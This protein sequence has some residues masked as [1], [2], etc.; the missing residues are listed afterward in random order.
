MTRGEEGKGSIELS[1]SCKGLVKLDKFSE[2]DPRIIVKEQEDF[3]LRFK[4]IGF[5]EVLKNSPNPRFV[6][7]VIVPYDFS[8][9]QIF[10]FE[11]YDWDNPK[12]TDVSGQDFIGS[13]QCSLSS[14]VGSKNHSITG[15]LLNPDHPNRKNG[16]I[17]ILSE[18]VYLVL[19]HSEFKLDKN[20]SDPIQALEDFLD[21]TPEFLEQN[22]QLVSMN[23]K[24]SNLEKKDW[25]GSSDP[26]FDIIREQKNN[27]KE[28]EPN[29]DGA[30]VYQS[31]TI[32]KNLN[33]NWEPFGISAQKLCNND[34]DRKL[35]FSVWDDNVLNEKQFIGKFVTSLNELMNGKKEYELFNDKNKKSGN[36][37]FEIVS[38]EDDIEKIKNLAYEEAYDRL[39]FE[40]EKHDNIKEG[41]YK[42]IKSQYSFLDYITAGC[43]IDLIIAIDFTI[44]N[45]F[46]DLNT[47]LHYIDPKGKTQNEYI[48]AI[49][50]VGRILEAYDHDKK[51]PCYGFGGVYKDKPNHCFP[52]N[53][54]EDSPEC[55]GIDGVL[56]TY[57]KAINIFPLSAP[58][59]FQDIIAKGIEYSKKEIS[60]YHILLII[61]DGEISDL[62]KTKSQIIKACE[63]PLSIVI[64]G[65]GNANFLSMEELDADDIP[66]EVDGK[67]AERDIV[68]FVSFQDHKN[69]LSREILNEIP[70]QLVSF[71]EFKQITPKQLKEKYSTKNVDLLHDGIKNEEKEE[72][73]N[74]I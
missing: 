68:Q 28:E 14:I 37:K 56:E 48:E 6:E 41:G 40:I 54:N 70:I 61:T 35:Q 10:K 51:I 42:E 12:S 63:Y 29:F 27:Q 67:V 43:Q 18:E 49:E 60:S 39:Q 5:T 4:E 59:N 33:P 22:I 74:K 30:A 13:F 3:T 15:T 69:D 55:D 71:F 57:K 9:E 73:M 52:L 25:W 11:V 66:I 46:P 53:K 8:K 17:T 38:I 34:F 32:K 47:S 23:C 16:Q 58:T 31:E 45:G 7:K 50:K 62:K 26:F 20:I 1:F 64:V 72:K 36:F 2:S 44:S 19:E 21:K 65:V 24:A